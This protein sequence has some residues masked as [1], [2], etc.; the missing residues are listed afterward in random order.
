VDDNR[1]TRGAVCDE[2]LLAVIGVLEATSTCENIPAWIRAGGLKKPD[3]HL[4]ADTASG[5]PTWFGVPDGPAAGILPTLGNLPT[6]ESFRHWFQDEKLLAQW[7]AKGKEALKLYGIPLEHGLGDPSPSAQSSPAPPSRRTKERH[8]GKQP[9]HTVPP[10]RQRGYSPSR[11]ST[12]LHDNMS[13]LSVSLSP[14]PEASSRNGSHRVNGADSAHATGQSRS[15]ATD[16]RVSENRDEDSW[17]TFRSIDVSIWLADLSERS[18]LNQQEREIISSAS[19]LV[20]DLDT[21][22]SGSRDEE[23][24]GARVERRDERMVDPFLA[25]DITDDF[26]NSTSANG[27]GF[28]EEDRANRQ[29]HVAAKTNGK[30]TKTGQT[31]LDPIDDS[32]DESDQPV[33]E[34]DDDF[35]GEDPEP[36]NAQYP[37]DH[38]TSSFELPAATLRG[39][40]LS[41]VEVARYFARAAGNKDRIQQQLLNDLLQWEVKHRKA[42]DNTRK[43]PHPQMVGSS[44]R[45]MEKLRKKIIANE[46]IRDMKNARIAN[47]RKEI[48]SFRDRG[49]EPPPLRPL[50]R[51]M[52]ARPKEKKKQDRNTNPKQ[53]HQV[54]EQKKR[55]SK[56]EKKREQAAAQAHRAESGPSTRAHTSTAGPSLINTPGPSTSSG[57]QPV[58]KAELQTRSHSSKRRASDDGGSVSVK[59]QRVG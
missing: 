31:I 21:R 29:K 36:V 8:G 54:P 18:S 12:D 10:Q 59:V 41:K 9:G 16:S 34:D 27:P 49:L 28:S 30:T 50:P 20:Y 47:R 35:V 25:A 33:D 24:N 32:D 3:I 13:R 58:I 23:T 45:H 40:V 39:N 15:Y 6:H 37:L 52:Q 2:I 51:H 5:D 57:T 48:K 19:R 11:P 26:F 53:N 56:E 55:K 38:P 7:I 46:D 14:Q 22:E 42:S 1:P 4:G 44:L 17:R 43:P